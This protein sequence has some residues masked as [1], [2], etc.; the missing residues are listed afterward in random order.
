MTPRIAA[1]VAFL[2]LSPVPAGAVQVVDWQF[3]S[4]EQKDKPAPPGG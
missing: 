1:I 2:L 3:G 4:K